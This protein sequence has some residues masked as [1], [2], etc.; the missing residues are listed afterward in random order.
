MPRNLVSIFFLLN[1]LVFLSAPTIISMVDDSIDVS[2]FYSTAEEEEHGNGKSKNVKNFI[3]EN[4]DNEEFLCLKEEKNLLSYYLK[5][6]SK[7][8]LNLISPPP[9]FA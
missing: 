6:Y 7:P 8:Y 2:L 5:D 9:K 1:F 4:T 3:L